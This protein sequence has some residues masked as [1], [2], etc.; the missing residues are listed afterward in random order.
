MRRPAGCG[1][2]QALAG[3][4]PR[5]ARSVDASARLYA[6]ARRAVASGVNSPVRHYAPHPFFAERARGGAV[7]DADGRRYVDLCCAYGAMLLGHR[8]A[9][10]MSAVSR[11]LRRGTLYCMPTAA[12][13]ELSELISRDYPSMRRVRLVNTGLEATMAAIRLARGHTGRETV[14]KFDG[15]YHG[16]HDYALVRAGSG[17]A[18]YGLAASA[19]SLRAAARHTRVARYNDAESLEGVMGEDV[20]AVIIEPVMANMG[21]IPPRRGFLRAVARI[22]RSHGALLIFDETVTGYRMGRGGAQ[23]AYG[24][25]PDITTLGK[26]LGGGLP[27]AAL[28][29]RADVM[30]SLAPL[31]PVYEA[32][33]FAGNPVSVGA[34]IA[35]VRELRRTGPKMYPRLERACAELA[36]RVSDAASD[37]GMEHAVNRVASMF[38]VFLGTPRVTDAASA[39]AAD[40]ARFARLAALMRERGVF[41][42]PSQFEAS[43]LSFAHTRADLERAARAYE[44]AMAGV[45]R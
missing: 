36:S 12:E 16:A 10:V 20:A 25:R 21:V 43:F 28:G 31:G 30:E 15:C 41:V 39:M 23:G 11:Q 44:G 9:A 18:H 22:A 13:T 29:G 8:S 42:P 38:Q 3:A 33:T 14:V 34:A 2:R 27:I 6:R 5:M 4:A 32:S 35:S 26:A 40:R 7:W 37:R 17:V 1:S 24:T 45:A 19:G